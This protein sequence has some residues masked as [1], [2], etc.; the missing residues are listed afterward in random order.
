MSQLIK[1][2]GNE[3]AYIAADM[4]ASVTPNAHRTRIVVEMKDGKCHYCEPDYGQS[5]YSSIDKLVG[6]I[7]DALSGG[8]Q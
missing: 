6:Q 1:L 8:D 5:I 2:P 3:T 7:N 4:V